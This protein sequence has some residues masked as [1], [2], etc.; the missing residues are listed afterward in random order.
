VLHGAKVGV[1][2]L[3]LAEV[4]KEHFLPLLSESLRLRSIQDSL[5][6]ENLQVNLKEI[7]KIYQEIPTPEHLKN[8]LT[9]TGGEIMPEQLGIDEQLV[10]ASLSGAHTLRNR[11]TALKF[12]NV[13]AESKPLIH[14]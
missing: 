3:L 11:F 1:S 9:Q 5:I 7:M 13:A 4:Y 10:A 2:T 14:P 8:L 12:M 6:N